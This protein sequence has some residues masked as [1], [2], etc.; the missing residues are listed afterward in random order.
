MSY[1][2]NGQTSDDLRIEGGGWGEVTEEEIIKENG[3]KEERATQS[4][5]QIKVSGKA[6]EQVPP[7]AEEEFAPPERE[8]RRDDDKNQTTMMGTTDFTTERPQG[9]RGMP[10]TDKYKTKLGAK[11]V[12]FDPNLFPSC[13]S[14]VNPKSAP[15]RREERER[16]H[17]EKAPQ[18]HDDGWQVSGGGGGGGGGNGGGFRR[19]GGDGNS[20]S[21]INSLAAAYRAG[22]PTKGTEYAEYEEE[23]EEEDIGRK[24]MIREI[25]EDGP[26]YVKTGGRAPFRPAPPKEDPRGREYSRGRVEQTP[27]M[28]PSWELNDEEFDDTPVGPPV[29]YGEPPPYGQPGFVVDEEPRLP[30]KALSVTSSSSRHWDAPSQDAR[31]AVGLLTRPTGGSSGNNYNKNVNQQ[32]TQRLDDEERDYP[33]VLRSDDGR[34][35][36]S[37]LRSDDERDHPPGFTS[38][39]MERTPPRGQLPS[40]HT[41]APNIESQTWV[42]CPYCHHGFGY[43]PLKIPPSQHDQPFF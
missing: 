17:R 28:G 14:N 2:C 21:R 5:Q 26:G 42:T 25:P 43:P 27:L 33:P 40:S 22:R 29:T 11:D 18:A 8:T 9:E 13:V 24:P 3:V 20:R 31:V 7:Q 6:A 15:P 38:V 16:S 12:G 39:P 36:P 34:D 19:P 1:R 37:V 41:T 4:I 35:H 32:P 10:R 23:E 30:P